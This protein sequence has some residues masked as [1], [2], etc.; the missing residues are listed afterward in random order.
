MM[1]LKRMR[2]ASERALRTASHQLVKANSRRYY[3]NLV[4]FLGIRVEPFCEQACS[5]SP[6]SGWNLSVLQLLFPI[7]GN[8]EESG[9]DV[10]TLVLV[11]VAAGLVILVA[12]IVLCFVL[13]KKFSKKKK[14]HHH[15]Q[16]RQPF[17]PHSTSQSRRPHLTSHD[18]IEFK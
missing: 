13:K 6:I 11:A 3:K 1:C 14:R 17:R 15:Q 4:Y 8:I 10:R 18:E 2:L 16:P 12:L 7:S 9:T 5:F